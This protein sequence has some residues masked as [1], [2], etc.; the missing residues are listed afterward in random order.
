[1]TDG[2]LV[3]DLIP[4]IIRES[5][6]R[7]EVHYLAGEE[8]VRAL[9]TKLC[10]EAQEAADVVDDREKLVGELADL[11]EVMSALMKLRG[12]DDSEVVQAAKLKA[13]QRGRFE[14]GVWLVGSRPQ[15]RQECRG[16]RSQLSRD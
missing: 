1:M 16:T 6:R 13:T 4:D 5:G 10:E 7:A 9:G 12:I 15:R 3:R 2:K 8:L 11:T 14:S